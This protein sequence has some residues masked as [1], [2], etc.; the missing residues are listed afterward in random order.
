MFYYQ[1]KNLNFFLVS[2]AKFL[3]VYDKKEKLKQFNIGAKQSRPYTGT[4]VLTSSSTSH[5][6]NTEKEYYCSKLNL[7][8]ADTLPFL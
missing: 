3:Q 2:I 6:F 7:F 1:N 5:F 4:V 8:W